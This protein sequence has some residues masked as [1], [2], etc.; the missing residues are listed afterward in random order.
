MSKPENYYRDFC[1]EMEMLC[2]CY[3]TGQVFEYFLTLAMCSVHHTNI[4]SRLEVKDEK[5]EKLYNSIKRLGLL[6][7]GYSKVI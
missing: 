7:K 2:C 4:A 5:N 3:D 1:K 6:I